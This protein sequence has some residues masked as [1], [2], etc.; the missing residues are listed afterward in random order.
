[1]DSLTVQIIVTVVVAIAYA[2]GLTGIVLPILPGSI[3]I[4][5]ASLVWAIVLGGWTWLAFA[6]IAVL[7][8]VGMICSY[9]M[10]GRRLKQH[11]VPTW[12]IVVGVLAGI[13]GIFVIPF[14]GLP[15]GFVIGLYGS[16]WYRRRDLKLAWQ[17]SWVA[18]KAFGIGVML[19][20]V[21]GF[22]S[23]LIFAI[24]TTV[25]FVQR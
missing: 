14:L 2:A 12:P 18:I 15:I 13:V 1:M 22:A 24:A 8:I 5:I 7:C 19:E 21:C 25:H 16:E 17:S 20:L 11:E 23:T 4:L 10:T 3:T 9:V 6:L